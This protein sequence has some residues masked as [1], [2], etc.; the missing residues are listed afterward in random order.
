MIITRY[1]S[2]VEGPDVATLMSRVYYRK[3]ANIAPVF[4]LI[5]EQTHEKNKPSNNTNAPLTV[6]E[7]MARQ[8]AKMQQQ[9]QLAL[10]GLTMGGSTNPATA[11][12]SPS[13][14]PVS[15]SPSGLVRI[16]LLRPSPDQWRPIVLA[17][18]RY[19]PHNDFLV[20]Y[21]RFI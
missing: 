20:V 8:K 15:F 11:T 12:T 1:Y 10:S 2:A 5:L 16:H 7:K 19:T 21:N 13:G 4:T 6:K 3:Q 14:L 18:K 9:Q 17:E